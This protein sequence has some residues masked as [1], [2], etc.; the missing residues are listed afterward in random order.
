MIR[1]TLD[2]QRVELRFEELPWLAR[3]VPRLIPLDPALVQEVYEVTYGHREPSTAPTNLL[4]SNIL[5]LTSNRQQDFGM[6]HYELANAFPEFLAERPAHAV[7]A[8]ISAVEALLAWDHAKEDFVEEEFDF[9]GT[10]AWVCA[11][12]SFQWD[13]HEEESHQPA[14]KLLDRFERHLES[15]AAQ[16]G[17]RETLRTI[18]GVVAGENRLAVVWRRLLRQAARLPDSL[19]RE[20]LPAACAKP[21]L[22]FRETSYLA[23]EYLRAVFG[24]LDAPDRERIE[25]A[26]MALPEDGAAGEERA[27]DRLL[28]CLPAERLVTAAARDH[29]AG[30]LGTM[31]VPP[32]VPPFGSLVHPLAGNNEDTVLV[33]GCGG[34]QTPGDRVAVLTSAVR[35]FAERSGSEPP[36]A[37]D[38]VAVVPAMR[39]L[40][41]ALAGG[42]VGDAK[43]SAVG[44]AWH[45][46]AAAGARIAAREDFSCGD[47]TGAF[48]VAILLAAS[49]R[50]EP[51]HRPEIDRKFDASLSYA[52]PAPR[53]EGA[54]GLPSLARHTDGA[55]AEVLERIEC[56]SR[57]P[58]PVVRSEVASRLTFLYE[59]APAAMWAIL[60]RLCREETSQGV[61][62]SV[63]A[64]PLSRLRGVCTSRV[65]ALALGILGRY[66]V[67]PGSKRIRG[68]CA[69]LLAQIY[70]GLDDPASRAATL[71]FAADPSRFADEA[72][73][74]A[75]ATRS[76]LRH[77]L[78]DGGAPRQEDGVR[79]RARDLLLRLLRSAGESRDRLLADHARVAFD[80]WPKKDQDAV[81]SLTRLLDQ[82]GIEV[83]H[84]SGAFLPS[85]QGERAEVLPE[86]GRQRFYLET[87]CLVDE[88]AD[89]G[90]A[91]IAHHLLETL[92]S[93]IP[94]DP[95]G[96]FVRMARVVR[97]GRRGN[98]QFESMAAD[99]MVRLV[100]R[101]LAEHRHVLREDKA[102][103]AALLEILD[104]FVRAGW[105]SARQLT[106]RIDE[107]YR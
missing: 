93:F 101:Y 40:A 91:S 39:E 24:R 95:A 32:N 44:S 37:G 48:I 62:V 50:P 78:T 38:M 13:A 33:P 83:Y 41:A 80:A 61:V 9:N 67:G 15:L 1:R 10:Q 89:I 25:T 30:L 105:P 63:I 71:G 29:L 3:Q 34:P 43:L 73:E 70:L 45:A 36:G 103:R 11:D 23:G 107:I 100:E 77:G 6:A 47:E 102:C 86:A 87:G 75:G 46:L 84:A 90:L 76:A 65:A 52:H 20:L 16:D 64:G 69:S 51:L 96:V 53:V 42:D 18:L 94:F 54:R 55:Q 79:E 72:P 68:R 104:V 60:E 35:D 14:M 99:L 88:L 66:D 31:R 8:L 21:I 49:R 4:E 22:T 28:G 59:S 98:Y 26:I 106:Y 85:G 92:E 12:G 27:R 57:D 97:S 58:V 74:L 56:L 19:G 5:P 7:R 17:G 82:I 81:K 2:A